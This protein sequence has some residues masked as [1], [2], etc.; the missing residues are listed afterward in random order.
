ML[1]FELMLYRL[2]AAVVLGIIVGI[3]REFIGK[4]AGIRTNMMVAA[5]SAIF[6]MVGLTL[7]YVVS[8]S[9]ENLP[10]VLAHNSGFLAVIANIVTGIGFLGAGIIVQEGIRVRGLTTAATVWYVAAV[11]V[12]CGIGL[13]RF[14]TVATIGSTALLFTFRKFNIPTFF[15]RKK[16]SNEEGNNHL[17]E[18]S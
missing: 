4:V 15:S 12:L 8:I 3:E 2:T 10:D 1:S 7:P 18:G 16:L 11:G 6:T 9:P 14:A 17:H 13:I 5:G